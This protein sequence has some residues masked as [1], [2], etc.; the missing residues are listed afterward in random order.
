MKRMGPTRFEHIIH[1]RR[2]EERIISVVR[3]RDTSTSNLSFLLE[4]QNNPQHNEDDD[5]RGSNISQFL[6]ISNLS[7]SE[8]MFGM[9]LSAWTAGVVYS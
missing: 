9:N 6:R 8:V 7:A 4:N 2:T 1:D 5:L 3:Y